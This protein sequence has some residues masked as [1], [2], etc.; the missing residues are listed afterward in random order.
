M[1]ELSSQPLARVVKA[2]YYFT[3][4]RGRGEKAVYPQ[5]PALK[6]SLSQ[7]LTNLLN[8]VS[9][10]TFVDWGSSY[11][12]KW[13][14]YWPILQQ[15]PDGEQMKGRLSQMELDEENA[16]LKEAFRNLLEV[17]AYD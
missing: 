14:D 12:R 2:S 3:T 5:T 11:D 7:V 17:L 15:N 8:M 13:E 1:R 6:T 16:S 4:M 9:G 10:G